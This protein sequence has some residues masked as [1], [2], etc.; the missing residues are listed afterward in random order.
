VTTGVATSETA[1]K[2]TPEPAQQPANTS[3]AGELH[4]KEEKKK[5]R[6]SGFFSKLK[7]KLK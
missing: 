2:S 5:K 6:L 7:E 3:G 1:A 4:A